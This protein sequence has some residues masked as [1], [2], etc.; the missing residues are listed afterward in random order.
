M[1]D[2][3]LKKLGKFIDKKLDSGFADFDKKLDSRLAE[4]EQ[5]IIGEVG[6]FFEDQM[7]PQLEEK[8]DKS[9][10]ENLATKD[11]I[12]RIERK[13]KRKKLPNRIL[14]VYSLQV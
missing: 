5:R 7:L 13:L 12:E 2:E 1:T 14:R 8:A 4:T 3:Q 10:L 11:D 6:Q 9:D